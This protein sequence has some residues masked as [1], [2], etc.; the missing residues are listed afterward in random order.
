MIVADLELFLVELPAGDGAV[1]T[2]LVRV[3]SE[4]GDEGWGE[5]RGSWHPGQLASRRKALLTA[6][7]GR[8]IHDIESIMQLDVLSDRAMACG[9]EMALW[10][11]VAQSA[12]Q[13]LCH[14]LGG[15]YRQSI[16]LSVRLPAGSAD[17]VAH[18]AR[19]FSAQSI[20]AQ[21]IV[22]TGTPEVDAAL[23]ST[24]AEACGEGV[25]FRLDA[26][27]QYDRRTAAQLAAQLAPSTVEYLLDPLGDG[28]IDRLAELRVGARV[29]LAVFAEITGA[30]DVLRVVRGGA[31]ACVLLDPVRVGGLQ[32]VR[33]CAAVADAGDLAAGVRI[34]RTSGL[35]IAATLQL[36]AATPRLTGAH[37]CSYPM[38]HDDLL[39]EP[40]K[41]VD[42]CL[43]VP[44]AAGLGVQVDRDKVDWYQVDA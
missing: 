35:A 1:R 21:T 20:L 33:R 8:Q 6:L 28:Q 44:L 38:L 43:A 17:A 19:V 27:G 13:P 10:D 9:V 16:P 2:L 18:L 29:P 40:L 30:E 14:L 25:Q 32:S 15:A 22:A 37:E 36:A 24:L 5:T 39:V 42:G 11:L 3:A 34:E 23:P 41:M 4:S 31:A 26:R 12:G 7:A